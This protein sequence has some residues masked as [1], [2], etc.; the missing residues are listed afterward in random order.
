MSFSML[1]PEEEPIC[2]C[3]YDEARDVMDR[4]DCPFHCDLVDDEDTAEDPQV[5][6]RRPEAIAGEIGADAA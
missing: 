1:E 5:E 3:R 2:E 6:R 4:E